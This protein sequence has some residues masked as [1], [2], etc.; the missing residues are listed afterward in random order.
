MFLSVF[1]VF[2]G[3]FLILEVRDYENI[4]IVVMSL[5]DSFGESFDKVFKMF[6][7]GYLGGFI[8]EKLVF[9]YRYLNEF[10]MFFI[11][12]KNSLNLVFSFLGLKNVVCLEVEKNVFNLNEVIK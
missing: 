3:Y 2:G 8:V 4:K 7:L 1:L 11:F 10:L 9:D 12:L 5:D 6:D